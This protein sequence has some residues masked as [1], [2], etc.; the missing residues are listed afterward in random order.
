MSNRMVLILLQRHWVEFR[1]ANLYNALNFKRELAE[2]I[3]WEHCK[4]NYAPDPCEVA[5]GV[6]MD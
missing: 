1:F 3:E 5:K 2:E 6:H 4:I